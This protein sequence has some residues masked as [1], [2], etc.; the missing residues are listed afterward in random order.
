MRYKEFQIVDEV[1]VHL[2]NEHFLVRT[3][4]K[5]KIK[6]FGSCKILKRQYFGNAYQVKL[7]YEL[8]IFLVFNISDLTK[9]YEGDDG[10]E[11]AEAQWSIL[12]GTSATKEIEEIV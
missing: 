1:M 11:A 3:Y 4:N 2:R 5:L 7:P 9:Y 8:N 6:K 12:V 10:D